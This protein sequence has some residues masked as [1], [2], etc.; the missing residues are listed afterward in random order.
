[1]RKLLLAKDVAWPSPPDR[2]GQQVWG[3]LDLRG[4]R[5]V[6]AD[7]AVIAPL[8]CTPQLAPS[9]RQCRGAHENHAT[10]NPLPHQRKHTELPTLPPAHA[11]NHSRHAIK[12]HVS[13]KGALAVGVVG[14][15]QGGAGRDEK[16]EEEDGEKMKNSQKYLNAS[17]LEHLASL[18]GGSPIAGIDLSD[19]RIA[20]QAS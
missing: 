15:T 18:A 10:P 8:I 1:M 17:D 20:G 12:R 11:Q 16:E 7:L 19:N 6:D 4:L 3:V 5:I 13:M 2:C 9:K 14:V